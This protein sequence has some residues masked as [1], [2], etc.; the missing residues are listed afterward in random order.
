MSLNANDIKKIFK[1]PE[2]MYEQIEK[3]KQQKHW[4]L[5]HQLIHRTGHRLNLVVMLVQFSH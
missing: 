2:S 5:M 4:Q 1:I 3:H